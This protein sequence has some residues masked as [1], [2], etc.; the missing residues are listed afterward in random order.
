MHIFKTVSENTIYIPKLLTDCTIL[1]VRLH[2]YQL[3]RFRKGTRKLKRNF[4]LVC[5]F[6]QA[7]S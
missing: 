6:L 3:W 1:P 2:H 7:L 5:H 4:P